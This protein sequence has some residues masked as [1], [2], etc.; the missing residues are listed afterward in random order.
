MR[1]STVK[2]ERRPSPLRD[3]EVVGWYGRHAWLW[4]YRRRTGC[5]LLAGPCLVPPGGASSPVLE[6]DRMAR[7][8]RDVSQPAVSEKVAAAAPVG[9]WRKLCP[10]V[11]EMLSDPTWD[12]GEPRATGWVSIRSRA[13]KWYVELLDPNYLRMLTVEVDLPEQALPG[14][15]AALTASAPP[16]R[17]AEWLSKFQVQKRKKK[18]A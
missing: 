8:K 9:Q 14:L 5:R 4:A 2:R 16:W 3:R 11:A 10:V 15:E 6:V 1:F 18:G 13:G 7:M 17:P 12:D